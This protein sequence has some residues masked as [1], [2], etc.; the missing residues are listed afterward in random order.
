MFGASFRKRSTYLLLRYDIYTDY[1]PTFSIIQLFI[2]QPSFS[3]TKIMFPMKNALTSRC[4]KELAFNGVKTLWTNEIINY[5][6]FSEFK[7]GY[8]YFDHCGKRETLYANVKLEL[9]KVEPLVSLWKKVNVVC[10]LR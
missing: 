9:R 5:L 8:H 2:F 7:T 10:R 1:G 3:A 4:R 6:N